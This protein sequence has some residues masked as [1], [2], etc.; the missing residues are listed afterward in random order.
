M[1]AQTPVSTFQDAVDLKTLKPDL[2]VFVSIGGWTF[3]DDGTATEPVFG[4]I[5]RSLINRQKFFEQLVK[6]PKLIRV[7]WR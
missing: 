3:S 4:N 5:A 6:V 2:K 7:R 1:D